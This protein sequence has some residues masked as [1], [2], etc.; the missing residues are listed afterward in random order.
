MKLPSLLAFF[1]LAHLAGLGQ[2]H[3]AVFTFDFERTSGDYI[4]STGTFETDDEPFVSSITSV[5]GSVNGLAI[6]S[7]DPSAVNIIFPDDLAAYFSF[8]TSYD[9]LDYSLSF[10]PS[11]FANY[12]LSASGSDGQEF[13]A[14]GDLWIRPAMPTGI[15]PVSPVPLPASAP[16]FSV[17]I[18]ALGAVGYGAKRNKIA[19]ST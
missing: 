17:A 13:Q 19:A 4:R 1:L 7:I 18:L 5:S 9:G 6:T 8:L 2:S 16:L 14:D 11:A 10:G 15:E 12:A 3:A